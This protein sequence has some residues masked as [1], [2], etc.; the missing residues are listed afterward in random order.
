MGTVAEKL[1]YLNGTKSSLKTAINN[2]G[3]DIDNNTTFRNYANV[4]ND[5]YDNLPK[6]SDTGTNVSLNPTLKGRLGIVPKGNTYQESTTGKNI[7]PITLTT[8]VINGVQVTKNSDGSVTLNG[9][10]TANTNFIWFEGSLSLEAGTYYIGLKTINNDMNLYLKNGGNTI[11]HQPMNVE[12]DTLTLES[13]KTYTSLRSYAVSGKTFNNVTFY[14]MITKTLPFIYEP[15]TGGQASPSPDYPQEIQ[16]AT[17]TQKVVVS[18]KNKIDLSKEPLLTQHSNSNFIEP[19]ISI[20]KTASNQNAYCIFE[21]G[22]AKLL[23]GKIL[24]FT[25]ELVSGTGRAI[26]GYA[27]SNGE[28]RVTVDGNVTIQSGTFQR[29]ITVDGTTYANKK[30]IIWL[31]SDVSGVGSVGDTLTYKN[32][33]ISTTGGTYQPYQ[34]PQEVDIELGSRNKWDEEWE[35]GYYNANGNPVGNTENA[36]RSKNFI[37]VLPETNIYYYNGTN[38]GGR[39]CFY[40]NNKNFI[41]TITNSNVIR[42]TP[43]NCYYI[44]FST[45]T[46]YGSTYN[47]DI[48]I[49][50][51]DEKNGTYTPY[52]NYT[53]NKIGDYEDY[54]GG[55]PDN[56]VL[57]KK[58]RKVELAIS[59]M[60]NNEDYPGWKNVASLKTD[61]VNKNT[62]LN[63]MTNFKA[64]ITKETDSGVSINTTGVNSTL[65]LRLYIFNLTQTQWKEQ[66][67]N[68]VFELVYGL[69]EYEQTPITEEPLVSQLNELYYLQSYNDTTNIDV[70]GNL[71]MR[72]TASA[73][74][75]A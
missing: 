1:T 6:V 38:N 42:T 70:T 12:Y 34:E 2:L 27:D 8:Q 32:V 44:M 4:L 67:P 69:Q 66:Y 58:T 11:I 50:I 17:G 30:V 35:Q 62:T 24:K 56:W 37:P 75:G 63:T 43:A 71:P 39:I 59:D 51:S 41:S 46:N 28:N 15:Y 31:Y 21:V 57:Y 53:P 13:A 45:S 10:T 16:S 54:I 29:T 26:I 72:I 48:C 64:N 73:I 60:N 61:Y 33:M 49:N 19:N 52:Y 40:D 36:I 14:P 47:N 55:T 3:G 23:D 65:Y 18:G 7:L 68:L 9:T 25:G 5:I 20:I 74:K 22:D